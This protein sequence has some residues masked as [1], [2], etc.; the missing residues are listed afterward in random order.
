MRKIPETISE[1][2]LIILLKGVKKNKIKAAFVLGFYQ[3]LRVSEVINLKKEDVNM[4]AGF[5][6]VKQGKGKKDRHIPIMKPTLFY[7]RYLPIDVT[8]Q[9]LHKSIVMYSNKL[10]K[11][12]LHFHTLRHSGAT[13]YLNEKG[14][15]I[16]F[17]QEL[18]GHSRLD[19]TQIYTHVNPKQLKN[20]FEGA[21][22]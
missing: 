13:Y 20:V 16:R 15:D 4:E 21:W 2:E 12:K 6:H 3:C 10:L 22:V 5:L 14:I 8:R 11:K 1:E 19:T 7:L 17:L 18:L 9:A